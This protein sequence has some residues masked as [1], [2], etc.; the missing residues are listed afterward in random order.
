MEAEEK[1]EI[2]FDLRMLNCTQQVTFSQKI[3]RITPQQLKR[4]QNLL[5]PFTRHRWLDKVKTKQISTS[6][7][8]T[9]CLLFSRL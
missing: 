4:N 8:Q 7:K 2:I 5:F 3:K 1:D 9:K 6:G